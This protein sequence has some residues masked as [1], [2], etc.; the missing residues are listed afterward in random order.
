AKPT[1]DGV[2]EFF[3]ANGKSVRKFTGRV[4]RPGAGAAG[5]GAP[6]QA[7]AGEGEGFG[8]GG[9]PQVPIEAGLNRFVWDMRYGE[10]VRF[11]GMILWSGETRGPN[12]VPGTY[13][14]KLT[15][16]GATMTE[17]FEVSADPRLTTTAADYAKQLGLSVNIRD[18]LNE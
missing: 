5:S 7:R 4:P 15:L 17:N 18:K 2:I 11:P 13:Q 1:T 14:V 6:A 8:G 10:A 16:D 9:A 12:I 3:H